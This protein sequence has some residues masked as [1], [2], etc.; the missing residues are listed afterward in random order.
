VSTATSDRGKTDAL[1]RASVVVPV[2]NAVGEIG[3]LVESLLAQDYPRDRFEIV[4]VDNGSTDGT[5]GSVAGFPVKLLK[6]TDVQSSYAA[7]NRALAEV[8]GEWVAFTDADCF[9]PPGGSARSWHRRYR[10]TSA[11]SPAR[12]KLSSSR[13]RCS[14]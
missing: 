7:R 6:E 9:A 11:P 4:V 10:T 12:S 1:P 14:A 8:T 5:A 2:F 3:R 13:Q